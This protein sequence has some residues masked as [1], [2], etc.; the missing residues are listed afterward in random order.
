M[1][2]RTRAL[3]FIQ[4]AF[5]LFTLCSSCS[6]IVPGAN[7]RAFGAKGNGIADDTKA[8]R[9]AFASISKAG[10]TVY[11]PKGVYIT[12]VIDIR[13]EK[14]VTV[15]V[16]GDG[17]GSVVK[18]GK[19][20]EKPVAV[21]FCEIE[22]VDLTFKNL[23]VDG[24]YMN[25]PLTWKTVA[26]GLVDID[27]RLNGIYA[28]NVKK[29]T[30]TACSVS[31]VHG[32]AIAC[33]S[34][35][36]LNADHN[37]I[38]HASGAGIKGHKVITMNVNNNRINDCGLLTDVYIL[39]GIKKRLGAI[40]PFTSFGDGIEAETKNLTARYNIINNFGRCAIVHDL[41]I[42]LNFQQSKAVVTNNTITLNDQRINNNNPPAG[43][44]FEQTHE[45]IVSNNNFVFLKSNSK[46]VSAIRFYNVTG[47]IDCQNNSIDARTYNHAIENAVGIFEPATRR[48]SVTGNTITGRFKSAVAVSY[49][50]KT[51]GIENLAI[52]G[53]RIKGNRELDYG[54]VFSIS[55]DRNFPDLTEISN[56]E[57][58]ALNLGA[59]HFFYYGEAKPKYAS[60]VVT[61]KGNKIGGK[62]SK[63]A[64]KA[65]QGVTLRI[66]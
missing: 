15:I 30:V 19:Q 14:G 2:N 31:N 6:A 32:E 51:A 10:G 9:A 52:N 47:A 8:I 62:L 59:Y 11:F 56:N 26:P 29:L 4:A 39:D 57:F 49:Q 23:A 24:N 3:I 18:F 7:V 28:Y 34:A 65:P 25:R 40:R 41:A 13:P 22:A 1:T 21:F 36:E 66:N 55:S 63:P 54:M 58:N 20:F 61:L 45:V 16:Q 42:D 12:D 33:Y 50:N 48:I 53:N 27:Q 5:L 46:I 60:A 43:M 44:W 38:A 64:I 17:S 35:Q 37:V